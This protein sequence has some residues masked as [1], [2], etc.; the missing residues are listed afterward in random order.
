MNDITV[1]FLGHGEFSVCNR[2]DLKQCD[3]NLKVGDIYSIH[4][5]KKR[6]LRHH[7]IYWLQM[8]ALSFHT[9]FTKIQ[10]HRFTCN[11][12]LQG[13]VIE[14]NGLKIIL[15]PSESFENMVDENEFKD[16][17]NKAIEYWSNKGYNLD[18]CL[19]E[20]KKQTNKEY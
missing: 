19:Q 20:Y 4:P 10:L 6:N 18:D 16:Y 9:G 17:H 8:T 7:N 11:E 12:I 5:K 2:Y 3:E 15:P 13:K 1:K 14:K